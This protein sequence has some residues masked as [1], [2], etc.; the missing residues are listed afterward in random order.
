[1]MLTGLLFAVSAIV[2]L[3]QGRWAQ[4]GIVS[5]LL[6]VTVVPWLIERWTPARVLVS[7][8][9]QYALLLLAA[10]FAGGALGLYRVWPPWDTIVHFYSGFPLTFAL[11]GALGLTLSVYQLVL[12]TWFEAVAVITAKASIALVWEFGEFF[13][14]QLSGTTTQNHNLDTMTDMLASLLPGIAITAAL[15]LHRRKGWFSYIGSLLHVAVPARLSDVVAHDGR[16]HN[17]RG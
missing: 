17:D 8:Q 6:V 15:V 3:F 1:M 12:P 5:L 14:D 4:T 16:A 11:I 10:P 7:L 9:L 2:F 13:V